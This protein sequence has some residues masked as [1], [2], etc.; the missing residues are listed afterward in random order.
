MVCQSKCCIDQFLI[1][2]FIITQAG[3][4]CE[5]TNDSQRF[6]LEHFDTIN[7]SPSHIYHSA[8]PCS[9]SSS[10]LHKCYG[11]EF[12]QGAKVT[13][14]LPTRWGVCCRTVSVGHTVV[15]LSCYKNTVAVGSGARDIIFLDAITGS[16]TAVLSGHTDVVNSVVFSPDGKS[17]VSGGH[18]NT[19]KL[20]D[21]QT[22]G[23]VKTFS[24]HTKLVRSVSISAD[25]TMIASGSWDKTV[26][27][28]D[29]QKGECHC[30][31]KQRYEVHRV[32][33]SPTGPQHLLCIS[34]FTISQWDINGHQIG[35]TFDGRY[36]AFSS[37]GTQV[38]SYH[39]TTVTVRN[40]SSGEIVARFHMA[41]TRYYRY[42]CISPD[43][44]LVVA[45]TENIVYVWDIASS[46]PHLIKAFVGH[47]GTIT[48]LIF[49]SPT[50]FISASSDQT[51]R[52]WQIHA[53]SM[54]PVEIDPESSSLTS[55]IIVSVTLHTEHGIT[56]TSDSD[57]V[58]RTWDISTGLC[59]A[60]FQ[61]P[62]KGTNKR[63]V[64]LTN[65]GLVL[66]WCVDEE[67]NI[68]DVEKEKLLFKVDGPYNV[69]DLKLSGDG[70]KV[71]LLDSNSVKTWSIQTGEFVGT[72]NLTFVPNSSGSLT[73]DGTKVWVHNS[74][75]ED[76]VW[77]FGIPDSSPVQL[78]IMPL[79]RLHPNGTLIW[80]SSLSG[81]KE[82]AT[83]RVIFRLSKRYGR[84]VHV[85]WIGQHL[86]A[87]FVSGEV[88]TLDFGHILL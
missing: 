13:K 46:E 9:P 8:L 45:N 75:S 17:L 87:C 10:W 16:Q 79:T 56:I 60:S 82:E 33:F 85:H 88:L 14:G 31:I 58:V 24:G 35:P 52:F 5:W 29:I 27:L 26:H 83:G 15:G 65:D 71:F 59:K 41:P 63:D 80:D 72:T 32:S 66:V 1:F 67:L 69:E 70:S 4:S 36:V 6:L 49:T 62:A 20:W 12:S 25:N 2:I 21:V 28:W 81:I 77:D 22:G 47:S 18:D 3:I 78:P 76:E 34:G 53:P 39:Q 61:T 54:D 84:P 73:V 86:V 55:A 48:S 50:S 37:D 74:R 19:V 11:T 30:V 64:Q 44:R 57:G 68:W 51:I 23:V 43:G 38:I 7:D 42:L 40:F